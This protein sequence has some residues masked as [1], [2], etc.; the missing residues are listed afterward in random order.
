MP[1][2]IARN[3]TTIFLNFLCFGLLLI[4]L[5]F[6][7]LDEDFYF[8]WHTVFWT[9]VFYM[10]TFIHNTFILK[11]LLLK[12]KNY[13]IYIII[14]PLYVFLGALITSQLFLLFAEW[15]IS[16][17]NKSV[18]GFLECRNEVVIWLVLGV[19]V[20]MS[21]YSFVSQREKRKILFQQTKSE[22]QLLKMQMH[23]HFFFNTLNNLYG[24][25]L[26]QS[27]KTP[28]MILRVSDLMRYNLYEASNE[29]NLLTKEVEFLQNYIELKKLCVE[30]INIKQNYHI[31]DTQ[32]TMAPNILIV[33]VEN[34]F[35]H[36]VE[37]QAKSAFIDIQLQT[38]HKYI[39]FDIKN[40]SSLRAINESKTGIGLSNVRKHLDIIYPFKYEL[41]TSLNES[42]FSV[43]LKIDR[44]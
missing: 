29:K 32:I 22:L 27:P 9:S 17:K 5:L 31:S 13:F 43:T 1:S 19:I 34:A 33:F 25:A 36:G 7:S 18:M 40:N 16:R 3:R 8:G 37:K 4:P 12:S 20:Y 11:P 39:Y 6:L 10:L 23:P 15:G 30:N 2:F 26:E 21:K 24:L 42:V 35:K 28:E 41:Q 38:D 14:L 44:T